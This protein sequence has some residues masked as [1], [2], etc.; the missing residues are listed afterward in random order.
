PEVNVG[1]FVT[2]FKMKL[3]ILIVAVFAGVIA[4]DD[5]GSNAVVF[6][7][8]TFSDAVTSTPHFVMFYA[9]WCGH[10][11]RLAPTW[12]ELAKKFNEEASIIIG[13]VDCTIETALCSDQGV[14]GYPTLK[15]F[16]KATEGVKYK[17]QRQIPEF[18]K[19]M[20]ESLKA[21]AE[22]KEAE[23]PVAT[24]EA[25]PA[26]PE[27]KHG[28][29][30]L[31]TDTFKSHIETGYHFVK[32]Y[33]P[34]CGHCK[35]LAPV[36]DQLAETFEHVEDVTIAKV[37]CTQHGSVCQGQGVRGY[38]TLIFFQNGQMKEKFG[39]PRN[40]EELKRFVSKMKEAGEQQEQATEGKIPEPVERNDEPQPQVK[41]LT[42]DNFDDSV[43]SGLSFVKFYAPWCGHCKRL[44]PTWDELSK[45]FSNNNNV[46]VAKVDCTEHKQ[47]CKKYD[48]GGYPTLLLF[49]AGV[50]IDEYHGSRDLEALD[51]FVRDNLPHDEL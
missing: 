8:E 25:P 32:F 18:E 11:K 19:F 33:A 6:T 23:V 51:T 13:K 3:L 44:A 16:N 42:S 12:D 46:N 29:Y 40:H 9:P 37:D 31:T 39:G 1:L 28:L 41:V 26:V 24:D 17:G 38:P 4:D 10:C 50:K 2:T 14:Q 45:K 36:W 15:F 5:H 47:L 27:A 34:W 21:S 35:T 48:V 20:K 30:E 49:K 22:K 7:R 43:S